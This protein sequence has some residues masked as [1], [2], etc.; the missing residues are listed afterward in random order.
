MGACVRGRV[1]VRGREGE[2]RMRVLC[3]ELLGV[4][5]RACEREGVR[6]RD[7]CARACVV[8]CGG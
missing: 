3:L 4:W 8:W 5:V 2:T 1:G 7:V 6:E